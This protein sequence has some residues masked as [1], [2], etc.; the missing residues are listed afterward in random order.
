M[1]LYVTIV[2]LVFVAIAF[3]NAFA[4]TDN[5][6]GVLAIVA[7]AFNVGGGAAAITLAV[8][9]FFG[10]PSPTILRV[11]FGIFAVFLVAFVAN[12]NDDGRYRRHLAF[13]ACLVAFTNAFWSAP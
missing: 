4:Q 3:A 11:A 5:Q 1:N 2:S 7:T 13:V 6:R 8:V 9:R 10:A 12:F